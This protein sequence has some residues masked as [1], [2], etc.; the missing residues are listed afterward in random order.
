MLQVGATEEEE[1][2]EEE[3]MGLKTRARKIYAVYLNHSCT[4]TKAKDLRGRVSRGIKT[5]ATFLRSLLRLV[6]YRA[7]SPAIRLPPLQ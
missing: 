2:E 4:R 6:E 1:A 3:D 7:C 5:G